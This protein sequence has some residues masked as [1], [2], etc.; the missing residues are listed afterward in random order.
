[1]TCHFCKEKLRSRRRYFREI[2]RRAYQICDDCG[3]AQSHSIEFDPPA[4]ANVAAAVVMYEKFRSLFQRI[5][6]KILVWGPDPNSEGQVARKRIQI[7]D[8]LKKLGHT[9]YFSE[10]LIFDST[11]KVPANLQER[12]Q[13]SEMDAIVCL[14]SD[15]GPLQEAQEFGGQAREFL[16]WLS[17]KARGKYTDSGLAQQL[18]IAHREPLFFHDDD[19]DSCVVAAASA[20]WIE[21]RRL[22]LLAIEAER[23]RL[24]EMYPRRDK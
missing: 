24:D 23:I 12:I 1:M 7:R 21:Q 18:R 8:T 15:F 9:V 2:S 13:V 16:L 5:S 11:Y 3:R 20:E 4:G 14:A 19:L 6:L 22:Q 17:D 10:E